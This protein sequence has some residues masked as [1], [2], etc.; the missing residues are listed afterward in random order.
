MQTY[1]VR[2]FQYCAWADR[3]LVAALRA[4][5]AAHAEGLALLGHLL[6]AE[7][8]WLRRLG[9]ETPQHAVWPTLDLDRC[10]ALAAENERGYAAF[11]AA[12]DEARLRTTV[13]YRTTQGQAFATSVVDILTQVSH[14]GAYHRGQLAKLLKGVGAPAPQTDFITFAR[15]SS[16]SA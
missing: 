8:V 14:H 4:T 7:H 5:P 12:L 13:A 3:R 2:C 10:E 16:P 6:A 9:G 15:E 1:F 11:C